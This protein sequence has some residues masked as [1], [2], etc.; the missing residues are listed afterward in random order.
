VF[1]TVDEVQPKGF[2]NPVPV[3]E[4]RGR[5]DNTQEIAMCE[6][7]DALYPLLSSDNAA[8]AVAA[9]EAFAQRY[10]DDPVCNAH[11]ERLRRSLKLLRPGA[12]RVKEAGKA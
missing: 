11:L 2:A 12:A 4:L 5:R 1:R 8:A 3:F 6:E 10:P 9:L 7:W